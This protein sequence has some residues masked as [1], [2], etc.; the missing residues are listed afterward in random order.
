MY[1]KEKYV[2]P[3]WISIADLQRVVHGYSLYTDKVKTRG[4]VKYCGG[5]GGGVQSFEPTG[6]WCET[7]CNEGHDPPSLLT[8]AKPSPGKYK[9]SKTKER[10]LCIGCETSKIT[11]FIDNWLTDDDV[12]SLSRRQ[13]F[14]S[15][16]RFMVLISFRG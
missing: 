4:G 14:T 1:S 9:T 10:Y 5:W 12:V 16:V 13:R 15:P 7:F 3:A 11:H 2:Y 6:A 8:T